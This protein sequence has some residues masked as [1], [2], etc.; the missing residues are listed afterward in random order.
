MGGT[1]SKDHDKDVSSYFSDEENAKI[2]EIFSNLCQTS[3]KQQVVQSTDFV[4]YCEILP[5]TLSESLFKWMTSSLDGKHHHDVTCQ[6][7]IQ[8]LGKLLR[9]T[10][11]ERCYIVLFVVSDGQTTSTGDQLV[12][13]VEMILCVLQQDL[14]CSKEYKSWKLITTDE[15][16]RR[17]ALNILEDLFHSGP[18]KDKG[19]K[20]PTIPPPSQPFTETEIEDWM[21]KSSMFLQIMDQVFSRCFSIS[22]D[23]GNSSGRSC[24]RLPLVVDI[25]WSKFTSIL[26]LPS[27]LYLNST[28]PVNL[29]TEWRL[30]FSNCLYGDSFVQLIQRIVCHGPTVV[31]VKDKNGHIFGGF[32]SESWKKNSNFYGD[33]NCYLF[34]IK[35]HLSV[36]TPTGYNQHYLYYNQH[37]TTLPNGLGFGGQ[38][39]YFGLWIDE[40]FSSGHSKAGPKNTTYGSPQLSITPEF[41]IDTIEVWGVGPEKKTD[42]DDDEGVT[43]EELASRKSILDKD[44]GAKAMLTLIGKGPLSEGLREGDETADNPEETTNT[45]ISLF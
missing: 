33:S 37:V 43:D 42:D 44:P 1:E 7:F 3:K 38:L 26:D 9:G 45:V 10:I 25:D 13:F 27:L 16:Y 28:L 4:K 5:T 30:L 8:C 29:Q 20:I 23:G 12:K 36:F 34:Q 21:S 41:E 15:G 35:P 31:I 24:P 11:T 40:S 14:S 32:A 18:S 39:E 22:S 17:L 6:H 2:H 19:M